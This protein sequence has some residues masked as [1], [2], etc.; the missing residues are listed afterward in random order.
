MND[1]VILY[2]THCPMCKALKM[3]L[4]KNKIDY[5]VCEDVELMISKGFSHAPVLEVNGTILSV[6]EAMRWAE[7]H[8]CTQTIN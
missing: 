3:K 2:T 1:K 4:D 6:K 8:K 7:E 5:E